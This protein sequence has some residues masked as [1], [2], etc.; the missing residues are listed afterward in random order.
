MLHK[1]GH[2][3][4]SD[5]VEF[6]EKKKTKNKGQWL[7]CVHHNKEHLSGEGMETEWYKA[8]KGKGQLI[9]VL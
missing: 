4:Y 6:F 5:T 7:S 1:L 9:Q 3:F 2:P 8:E